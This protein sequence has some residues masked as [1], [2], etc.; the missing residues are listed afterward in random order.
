MKKIKNMHKTTKNVIHLQKQ[1]T[2]DSKI[3]HTEFWFD[4]R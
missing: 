4:K 1:Q 2:D 3:Q